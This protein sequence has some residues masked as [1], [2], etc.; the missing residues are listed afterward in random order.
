MLLSMDHSRLQMTV[1]VK[2]GGYDGVLY[3]QN[4]GNGGMTIR[5]LR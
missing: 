3:G 4:S 2:D 5:L 1:C